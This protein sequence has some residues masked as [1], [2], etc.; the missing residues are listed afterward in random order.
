MSKST[1]LNRVVFGLL[2][3]MCFSAS[4]FSQSSDLH[5][6]LKRSFIKFDLLRLDNQTARRVESRQPL[7]ISTSKRNYELNLTPRD[8]RTAN[9]RAEETA[10]EGTR[11]LE[12]GAVTTFKGTVAGEANSQVR[13]TIDKG[14]I[15]GYLLDSDGE[16]FYIEPA[17]N[18]SPQAKAED[19][20]IYQQADL[21]KTEDYVCESQLG[22][23]IERGKQM[24]VGNSL[25]SPQ[26]LRVIEIATDADTAFVNQLGGAA[27]ANN[28]ILGILN[29][30]E[31][32]FETELGLT[33][34]V[35]F[36]HAWSTTDPFDGNTASSL[37]NSFRTFWNTNYPQSSVPRDVA[38][39]FSSRTSMIGRGLSY[40]GTVCVNPNAAYGLTGRLDIGTIKYVLTAHEISH[41]LNANH[42]EAP[43]G[44]GN[45]I[46]NATV[47]NV[48]PIDFCPFSRT[49]IT[50]FVAASGSCLSVRNV[51]R[52]GDDFDGDG[53][54]DV[55]VFRPSTGVWYLNGTLNGFMG[56]AFGATS[57]KIVPADYDGDRKTDVAVYRGGIWYLQRSSQGFTGIAFGAT[58]DIPVPADYTGDGQ[59]E[60][61]VFR[62]SNGTWY[63]LNLANNQMDSARFGQAGDK[64]VAADYDG[65]GKADVAVYRKGLWYLQRSSLGFISTAF[66][67][68]QDKPVPADYDGD[69]K[70]D[71]AVYRPANG[72]WY[73]QRSSQ[74]F[75]A[76]TFGAAEDF[77]SAADYDGDSKADITV[78][79]PSS[80]TWYLQRSSLGFTAVQFGAGGDVPIQSAYVQ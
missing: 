63:M 45:T 40:L 6:D 12:R 78:F 48:T 49:E 26:T 41:S 38:H 71:A 68:E 4:A 60:I 3:A 5:G 73:L 20:V 34:D 31:G 58:D 75:A 59:A 16:R 65:D 51:T 14:I 67:D 13:L 55:S 50:N 61:A 15:E 72:T 74:G 64:P 25:D 30:I 18:Y 37:L 2:C 56:M 1:F 32:D 11:A 21:V 8:L 57:D 35:V 52:T 24:V 17:I 77:P 53:K 66:G 27:N 36:Q 39:L 79:R 54:S 80:G 76:A 19:L 46:M 9:Y 47:S 42:A 7:I 43:Q 62:P 10:V 70:V 28:E 22:E 29:M 23:K 33:F 44:C 69:G